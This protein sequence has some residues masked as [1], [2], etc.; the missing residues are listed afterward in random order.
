MTGGCEWQDGS[1]R[2]V[3]ELRLV[4]EA[5]VKLAQKLGS[6]EKFKA[7]YNPGVLISRWTTEGRTIRSF[8]PP[9]A[10]AQI[11]GDVILP[12][13][14]FNYS[15]DY[16]RF[17]G[18]HELGHVWDYRTGMRLSSGLMS[19]VGGWV[20]KNYPDGEDCYIDM[21]KA[22]ELPPDTLRM[23]VKPSSPKD[24]LYCLQNLPYSYLDTGAGPGT[25]NWAQ[26]LAYY[27]YPSYDS[28][29][30]IRFGSIRRQYVE[31]QIAK[32]H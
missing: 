19:L 31:E 13:Y 15:D 7:A 29:N 10:P 26:A 3:G 27:V 22:K 1:W 9:G 2:S 8:A 16:A 11:L 4:K 14:T 20:C 6:E 24:K 17:E 23:C 21:S 12:A 28:K 18:V 5:V 25:E 32:L 30:T